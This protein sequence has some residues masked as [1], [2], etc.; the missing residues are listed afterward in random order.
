MVSLASLLFI[1]LG[2]AQDREVTLFILPDGGAWLISPEQ[3]SKATFRGISLLGGE[4]VD[5]NHTSEAKV[6]LEREAKKGDGLAMCILGVMQMRGVGFT[7]NEEKGRARIEQGAEAGWTDAYLYLCDIY[8]RRGT[9]NDREMAFRY[10]EM[11]ATKDKGASMA[12][13]AVIYLNKF[14]ESDGS[15]ELWLR[16]GLRCARIAASLG[17]AKGCDALISLCREG[18][19]LLGKEVEKTLLEMVSTVETA[20]GT[21]LEILIAQRRYEEVEKWATEFWEKYRYDFARYSLAITY[22]R[23]Y[24]PVKNAGRGLELLRQGAEAGHDKSIW[25]MVCYYDDPA[26]YMPALTALKPNYEEAMKWV[27]RASQLDEVSRMTAMVRLADYYAHGKGCERNVRTAVM[28]LHKAV[29][30]GEEVSST[31][32]LDEMRAM[33]RKGDKNAREFLTQY[34]AYRSTHQ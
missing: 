14:E 4:I 28:L 3:A 27:R 7:R 11:G 17:D 31:E 34:A 20:R 23:Y 26:K 6:I 30:L 16:E 29:S 24:D 21:L 5:E 2:Q 15:S 32:L 8:G 13:L 19:T 10:A 33:A 9:P 18:H 12:H 1:G 25:A 22:L